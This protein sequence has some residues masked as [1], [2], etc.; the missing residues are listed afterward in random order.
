MPDSSAGARW[1][2]I[3]SP[4][5][6]QRRDTERLKDGSKDISALPKELKH[7]VYL[8][9]LTL[10]CCFAIMPCCILIGSSEVSLTT[11]CR[12]KLVP[13]LNSSWV[14]LVFEWSL[15]TRVTLLLELFINALAL[16]KS[17]NSHPS[18]L[19][20]RL[21]S[22]AV[23]VYRLGATRDCDPLPGWETHRRRR[24]TS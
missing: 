11:Q 18:W 16:G 9:L 20:C 14:V 4:K 21:Q 1:W 13:V 15:K 3:G 10:P 24:W 7:Y 2:W 5:S 17:W 6:L 12:F 22:L 23:F 8:L 19:D